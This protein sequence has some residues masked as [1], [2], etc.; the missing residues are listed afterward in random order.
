MS[1]AVSF[2]MFFL[3]FTPLWISVLFIDA[4]SIF[5]D[6]NT[7]IYTEIITLIL[8]VL[9]F[10]T[11]SFVLRKIFKQENKKYLQTYTVVSAKEQKYITAEFLLSY[12]LPLFAFDF[13]VWSSVVLFIIFFLT[14][15]FLC[16]RHSYFSVNIV[17]EL[18]GYRFYECELSNTDN[19][20]I[21]KTVIT[22]QNLCANINAEIIAKNINNEYVLGFINC[23]K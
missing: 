15:A 18:L 6:H 12:I 20:K 21:S 3:S 13:T 9:V 4:K 23:N 11:S 10:I 2:S 17:L 14:F 19:K 16:I 22:K 8:I 5:I 1:I 7:S